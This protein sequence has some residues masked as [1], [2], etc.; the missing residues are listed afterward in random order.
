MQL[1][2]AEDMK[3]MGNTQRILAEKPEMQKKKIM[4]SMTP[5]KKATTSAT[6]TTMMSTTTI[7]WLVK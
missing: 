1:F 4:G 3:D 2:H 5:R 7:D 6:T